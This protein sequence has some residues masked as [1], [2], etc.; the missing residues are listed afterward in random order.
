MNNFDKMK[1][2]FACDVFSTQVASAIE[3]LVQL[4]YMPVDALATAWFIR[5]VRT[6]F[7][8]MN[9]ID[10]ALTLSN[11][12]TIFDKLVEF[13]VVISNLQFGKCWKPVKD[14]N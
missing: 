1:V 12:S 2:G 5:T 8:I 3:A 11:A 9:S 14:W 7:D 10:Q 13:E 4:S 6:W